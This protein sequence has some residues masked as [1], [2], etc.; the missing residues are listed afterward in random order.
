MAQAAHSSKCVAHYHMGCS[1]TVR[2][3]YDVVTCCI[4]N[5]YFDYFSSN[6]LYIADCVDIIE[7]LAGRNP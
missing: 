6:E 4:D 3:C 2:I 7:N 5:V 1:A